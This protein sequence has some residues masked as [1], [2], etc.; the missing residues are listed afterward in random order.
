[1][2]STPANGPSLTFR[3]FFM[4]CL[5]FLL[6][7]C[8]AKFGL[9]APG[10]GYPGGLSAH[11]PR[12][13]NSGNYVYY[14]RYEAYFQRSSRM[15][16][17]PNGKKWEVQPTVLST[18]VREILDSPGVPFQFSEH[19]SKYHE[20]VKLAFPTTWTPGKGRFD[21]PYEFGRSGWDI[22]RR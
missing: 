5:V 18:P 8:N 10:Y 2:N 21:E 16:Y 4:L 7:A 14:P 19:P 15:F 13:G 3:H 17:Y 20:D 9:A 11:A 6:A 12:L 22:D 1:M